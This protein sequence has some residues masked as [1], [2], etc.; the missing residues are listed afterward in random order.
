MRAEKKPRHRGAA[1]PSTLRVRG[2]DGMALL[3]E[4]ANDFRRKCS[5][6]TGAARCLLPRPAPA[7]ISRGLP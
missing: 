6:Y 2:V 1:R 3:P 5:E 4:G 7:A